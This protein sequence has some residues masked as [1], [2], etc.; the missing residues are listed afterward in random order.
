MQILCYSLTYLLTPGI[1]AELLN[2]HYAQISTDPNYVEPAKKQTCV[3]KGVPLIEEFQIFKM[4][5]GLAATS[6]GTD[7]MPHWFIRIAASFIS[8]PITHLFNLSLTTSIV[9]TQWKTSAI[10]PVPKIKQPTQCSDFRPISVTPILSRLLEKFVVRNYIYPILTHPAT[11]HLFLDQFAFRPTGST[12]SAIVHLTHRLSDLLQ[13]HPFVHVIALDFSKA[14]DTVRHNTLPIKLAQFPLPDFAYKWVADCLLG[15]KHLTKFERA[16][17]SVLAINASI[18][19]GSVIG[20]TA[21]VIDAS[22]L[23]TLEQANSL[24]KYADDTYLIVPASHSHT[25]SGELDNISAWAA[26]NNLSLNVNKSCETIVRRPR[27][28]IDDLIIPP[29]LPGVKRVYELN[30]LGV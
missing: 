2:T 25:I 17:S 13:E 6:S 24:D 22:D 11:H 21:Y 1:S 28:A 20:P 23:K 16:L 8:S 4:L 30:I 10:T 14:F 9:P 26:D 19:Q 18:I 7:G 3:G 15:R 12:T 5:D 29:A 27:L